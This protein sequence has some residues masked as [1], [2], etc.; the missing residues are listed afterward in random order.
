V[1]LARYLLLTTHCLL[2]QATANL[3]LNLA[4]NVNLLP[5]A[6]LQSKAA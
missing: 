4:C 2:S 3:L 6:R 1:L 5:P